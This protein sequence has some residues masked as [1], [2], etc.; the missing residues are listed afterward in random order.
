MPNRAFR[1]ATAATR[2]RADHRAILYEVWRDLREARIS[3]WPRALVQGAKISD[4][5]VQIKEGT[6]YGAI[7]QGLMRAFNVPGRGKRGSNAN[8]KRRIMMPTIRAEAW[9]ILKVIH[10]REL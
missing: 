9:A 8:R 10:E 5:I 2:R 7:F 6:L 4:R 3:G 1:D